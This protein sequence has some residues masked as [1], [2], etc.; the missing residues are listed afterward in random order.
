ME[1]HAMKI[2]SFP[3][4]STP[5]QLRQQVVDLQDEA[6]PPD[7]TSRASRGGHDP[8]LSPL[9]MLLVDADTVLAALDILFKEIEHDGDLY[10]AAGLST[11]VSRTAARR[12]GHGRRLVQAA[13]DAMPSMQVDVG[14]FTCDRP[15]K[16]FYEKSGWHELEGTVLIGGTPD[17][18]FPSDQP[19]FD[20][21]TLGDFFSSPAQN[22][23]P[24]FHGTRIALYPGQIDKLW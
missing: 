21:V 2:L 1:N 24:L 4:P 12:A 13:H 3:E 22:K 7:I 6:W 11:V 20:K 8:E 17:N 23:A 10:R 9:S 14:V 15:L 16:G 19:G 5:S 18:P